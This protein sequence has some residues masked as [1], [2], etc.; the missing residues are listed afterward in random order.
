MDVDWAV[1]LERMIYQ[2]LNELPFPR[3]HPRHR[4]FLSLTMRYETDV[5]IACLL[6]ECG[7]TALY[8]QISEALNGPLYDMTVRAKS[9]IET[10]YLNWATAQSE[11]QFMHD[12]DRRA[13][14]D[15][16]ADRIDEVIRKYPLRLASKSEVEECP[17]CVICQYPIR[18]RQHIRR[19]CEPSCV[20]HRACVDEWLLRS[21]SCPICRIERITET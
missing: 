7:R 8:L 20:F 19:L 13:R 17:K 4:E 5:E 15:S 11:E 2:H 6:I 21:R 10:S 1:E 18:K 9:Q 14:G 12:H 3:S 16:A